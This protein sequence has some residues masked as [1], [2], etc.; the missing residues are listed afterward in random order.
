MSDELK[1]WAYA[2]SSSP[3]PGGLIRQMER[4]LADAGQN[5]WQIVGASQ[6][7]STGKMLTRMGLREAQRAIRMKQAN[8]IL[9][10]SVGKISHE[11]Y[12]ALRVLEFLQD[13]SAVLICTQTDISYELHIKGLSQT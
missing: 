12:T 8:G 10:E 3:R 7:M 5:G 13:H 6:D 4:L 9:V 1:L 11:Y 2:R